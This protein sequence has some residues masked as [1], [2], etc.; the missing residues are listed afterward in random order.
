MGAPSKDGKWIRVPYLRF[1][2]M[3]LFLL[4]LIVANFVTSGEGPWGIGWNTFYVTWL[5][6]VILI[7][8]SFIF[9]YRQNREEDKRGES[10]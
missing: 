3:A 5:S 1:L 6:Y 4:S 10:K 9:I 2:G 8:T 7:V